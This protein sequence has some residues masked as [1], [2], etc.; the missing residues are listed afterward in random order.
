MGAKEAP[1]NIPE[2]NPENIV[3]IDFEKRLMCVCSQV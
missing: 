1:P 2:P 3:S